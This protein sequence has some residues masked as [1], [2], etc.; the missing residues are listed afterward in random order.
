MNRRRF[1]YRDLGVISEDLASAV[2]FD[3]T[4]IVM[5]RRSGIARAGLADDCEH[6]VE[7]E[8][9]AEKCRRH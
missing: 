3:F 5:L 7:T 1:K 4:N 8:M 2:F 9:N 6:P